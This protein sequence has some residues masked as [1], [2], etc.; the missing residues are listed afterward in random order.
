ME[1]LKGIEL[2]VVKILKN[3]PDARGN[4]MILFYEYCLSNW[5]RDAEMYR[6][7]KDAGFRKA[8]NIPVFESISRARRKAQEKYPELRPDRETELRRLEKEEEFI[9]YS[10]NL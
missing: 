5:V 2:N 10:Q 9:N 6:I 7:F 4:D 1:D 8:K 3:I